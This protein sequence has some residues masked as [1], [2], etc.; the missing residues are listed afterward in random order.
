MGYLIYWDNLGDAASS[1][2]PIVGPMT[3]IW[4]GLL[5]GKKGF[6]FWKSGASFIRILKWFLERERWLWAVQMS[7]KMPMAQIFP[8]EHEKIT[9]RKKRYAQKKLI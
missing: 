8:T 7:Y 6:V 2:K 5:L 3:L 4:N 9:C 1:G